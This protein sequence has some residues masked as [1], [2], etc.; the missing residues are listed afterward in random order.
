M[1]LKKTLADIRRMHRDVSKIFRE[2]ERK[3][4]E[5][6]DDFVGAMSNLIVELEA[7]PHH[8]IWECIY[9]RVPQGLSVE[10]RCILR[11]AT[12]DEYRDAPVKCGGAFNYPKDRY[13][14]LPLC[15][16]EF[17][18]KFR[19]HFANEP[20]AGICEIPLKPGF[21][22]FNLPVFSE[23]EGLP[24]WILT[25]IY[26]EEESAAIK[27]EGFFGIMEHLSYQTGLAWDKFL[28][29]AADRL[30]E[31]IDYKLAG[32]K[33]TKGASILDRLKIIS[34]TLS[35]EI[36]AE[37]CAFSLVE[38]QD[39]KP[40]LETGNE[41]VRL[42]GRK[43]LEEA[44]GAEKIKSLEKAARQEEKQ[45]KF[46]QG[47]RNFTPYFLFEQALFYPISVGG[48]RIG[49]MT[50]FRAKKTQKPGIE[51]SFEDMYVTRPFSEFETY[52]S[53]KVQRYV[54]DIIISREAAQ[55]RL[56]DIISQV[57]SPVRALISA[58]GQSKKEIT[59]A[60]NKAKQLSGKLSDAHALARVAEQYVRNFEVLLDI[61]IRR[62]QI[63]KE[64]I[65]DLRG[66]L[67]KRAGLHTP[68]FR[69]KC[70]SVNVTRQTPD[71]IAVAVDKEL[72]N[73]AI[74]NI[75]DNALKYSFD[76]EERERLG[77]QPKPASMEDKENV[78]IKAEEDDHFVTITVSNYGIEI[79]EKEKKRIFDRDFRGIQAPDR[80]KGTGIGL[81]V[82]K[83]I[84]EKHG[85]TIQLVRG[86]EKH[87]TL[88]SI[89]LPKS[90]GRLTGEGKKNDY[91]KR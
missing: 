44:M 58:T 14:V 66:Y 91:S 83:E 84:I 36:R 90:K 12:G 24:V 65:P 80:A 63:K 48:K 70:I 72:F 32:G 26:N 77:L 8:I 31:N 37:W 61:D 39:K 89:R 1:E 88:F 18:E 29:H 59:G 25:L 53:G 75:I 34:G 4:Y 38:E 2:K 11:D 6:L 50:L 45:E 46:K 79:A 27:D 78:L 68:V 15:K 55:K 33:R 49:L 81:F 5:S 23:D 69:R 3:S 62:L 54:F 67:I 57:I 60:A 13:F 76:P 64:I 73:L 16:K 71:N 20:P 21:S 7:F 9:D 19:D 87:N 17:S 42:S 10:E 74:F 56:R 85:G 82:P 51:D 43:Y 47:K 35:T 52:L 22:Y 28:K 30:L 40:R 41:I 86:R